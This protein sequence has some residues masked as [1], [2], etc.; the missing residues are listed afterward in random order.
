MSQHV[1]ITGANKGIGLAL[2]KK[3]TENGDRVT[4]VVR[5]SSE[6][7]RQ[8]DVNIIEGIDVTDIQSLAELK[9]KLADEQIDILLNNAGV[10]KRDELGSAEDKN[11]QEQFKV[12]SI[13]PLMVTQTLL[14]LLHTGSKI[15]LVSSR[16][17]SVTDNTSGAYYGYRMSKAALNA[18]GKSLANDL[19]SKDIA[20]IVL[21][22]GYV[23]TDM[24][25]HHGD[26]TA[27]EAASG[28][29]A[30]IQE[31]TLQTT[32]SFKHSNGETLPW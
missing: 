23:K 8:L 3:F 2:T 10:L 4:A 14:P 17:G 28:L 13:G 32:G 25:D 20:V 27:E 16:M 31:L 29:F 11:L 30:R 1:V 22:P 26:I 5:S 15:A 6:D 24:T 18:A 7:L 12:N 19:R 21:H 9:Q